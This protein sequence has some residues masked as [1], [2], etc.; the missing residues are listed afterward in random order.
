MAETL[1]NHKTDSA[2][3]PAKSLI[4]IT[5]SDSD[6]AVVIRQIYVGAG[7]NV[8]VKTIS[9]DIITFV[10]APQGGTL[11]PFFVDRVY[12]TDT[13]ASSLVGYV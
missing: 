12:A 5:T 11:G 1:F 2:V 3:I 9:G 8:K 4:S 6:Q 13:T 10:D 7:G